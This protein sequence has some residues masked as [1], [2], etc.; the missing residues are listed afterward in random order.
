MCITQR[1]NPLL[2]DADLKYIHLWVQIKGIPLHYLTKRIIKE[3]DINIGNYIE[4]DFEGEGAV[5]VDFVRVKLLWNVETPLR[6]Q[7]M[8]KFGN[9]ETVLKFRYE[10]LR[11]FCNICGMLTHDA[12][13]CP[14]NVKTKPKE[15]GDDDDNDDEEYPLGFQGD[16]NTSGGPE[17]FV[18][19]TA[20]ENTKDDK[21]STTKKRKT[22]A[23]TSN[24]GNQSPPNLVCYEMRQGYTTDNMDEHF[25]KKRRTI[26]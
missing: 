2:T 20:P 23:S 5:L 14:E 8:F 16:A 17:P 25:P 18:P 3:V 26:S 15:E 11:N 19:E 4:T 13:G 10:K 6:F 1:W 24:D 22:E 9:A 21:P 12:S 7:R